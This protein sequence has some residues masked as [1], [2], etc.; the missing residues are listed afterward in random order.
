MQEGGRQA[1]TR[2]NTQK[3]GSDPP[4]DG[5]QPPKCLWGRSR[6]VTEER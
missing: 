1:C 6:P 4:L 5:F 2:Q 3:A